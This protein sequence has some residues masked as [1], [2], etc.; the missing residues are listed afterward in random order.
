MAYLTK[1]LVMPNGNEYEFIGK[2]WYG[3]CATSATT[4][5]KTVSISGFTSSDLVAGVRVVVN[6]QQPQTYNGVPKLNVSNSGAKDIERAALTSSIYE[7][8][9]RYE[10]NAGETVAF[11]YSGTYW[12]IENGGTATTGYYGK[13]KLSNTIANDQTMALTPKAVYDAG[14]ATT[15]QLPTKTSDLTNDSGYITLAD[16]PI[17][18]G[19]VS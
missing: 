17:Y 7:Y 16:L 5:T 13:T 1:S 12:V 11:V 10:W 19:G 4:Q 2:T 14:F 15:S 8:A 18:N 9:G 6:F 3:V